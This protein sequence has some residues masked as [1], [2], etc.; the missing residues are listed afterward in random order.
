MKKK[1]GL[2]YPFRLAEMKQLKLA[3][4]NYP[5]WQLMSLWDEFINSDD[6]WAQKTGFS[7]NGFLGCLVWLVDKPGWKA[8]AREYELKIAPIDEEVLRIVK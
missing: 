7:I 1:G 5:E 2:K 3:K 8:R 4:R 6:E